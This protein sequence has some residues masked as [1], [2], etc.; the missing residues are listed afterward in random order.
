MT[1]ITRLDSVQSLVGV[2][3]PVVIEKAQE[4]ND[5]RAMA[6]AVDML[7]LTERQLNELRELIVSLS[8]C[9][10]IED[11]RK[12]IGQLGEVNSFPIPLRPVRS[13]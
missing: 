13:A 5:K 4:C 2:G 6:A 3:L 9:E 7:E 8:D 1:I 12:Q 10:N 11:V